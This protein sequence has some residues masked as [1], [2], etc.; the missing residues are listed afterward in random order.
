MTKIDLTEVECDAILKEVFVN[1]AKKAPEYKFVYKPALMGYV[2]A[3]CDPHDNGEIEISEKVEGEKGMDV[4][5]GIEPNALRQCAFVKRIVLPKTMVDLRG[6]M[7]NPMQHLEDILIDDANKNYRSEDGVLIANGYRGIIAYP[8]GNKRTEYIVPKGT[9]IGDPCCFR[10]N[11]YLQSLTIA[12]SSGTFN[13]Q[14]M[15]GCTAMRE[16]KT[17]DD[18]EVFVANEGILYDLGHTCLVYYPA[19]CPEKEFDIPKGFDTIDG[20]AFYACNN[21][22][23]VTMPDC[24][25]EILGY[26]FA[27]CKRLTDVILNEGLFSIGD[28]AFQDCTSLKSIKLPESLKK[29]YSHAFEGCTSLMNITIPASVDELGNHA[30]G[31]CPGL[32]KKRRIIKKNNR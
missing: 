3:D 8:R 7:F 29:I 11:P 9:N 24:M 28:H 14:A 27:Q 22:E 10:D 5:V 23:K 20:C 32:K 30:F 4:V 26:N 13:S 19:N 16:V 31:D 17:F 25:N 6:S 1:T 12:S 21:L 15:V 18:S 2:L